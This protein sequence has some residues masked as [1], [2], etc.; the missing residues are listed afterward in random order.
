MTPVRRQYLT[1]KRQYPDIIV[2]FRLGDFYETFD[3]DAETVARVLGITLTSREMGKGNRVPLAGIPYHAA[4]GYIAR[5]LAAGHKVAIAEQ[6]TQPNGRDLIERQVTSVV[7]PGTVTDPAFVSGDGNSYIVALL[8][9]GD[10]AGLAAHFI[11]RLDGAGHVEA[12]AKLARAHRP[13]VAAVAEGDRRG[14]RV[15]ELAVERLHGFLGRHPAEVHAPYV[16][17]G[18][19][20]PV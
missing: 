17:A 8:S 1:I 2:F 14:L 13:D 18:V 12:D 6:L 10:Q 11:G 20:Q 9:D 19:N 16:H 4:E 3:G 7:T 15:V 5:L